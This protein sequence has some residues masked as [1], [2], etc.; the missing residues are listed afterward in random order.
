MAL[1]A[2]GAIGG[3]V[4]GVQHAAHAGSRNHH[5]RGVSQWRSGDVGRD[6]PD[7]SHS[8]GPA[9]V[10]ISV[11]SSSK[12]S[13]DD[14]ADR[15][16]GTTLPPPETRSR[17]SAAS[18]QVRPRAR[19][20]SGR[21]VPNHPYWGSGFI[22]SPDGI[23]LTNAHVVK[24]AKE[25]TVKLTDRREY[26]A[27]VLGADPKPTWR[28]CASTPKTC[29]VVQLGKWRTCVWANGLAIGSPFG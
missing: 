17:F 27:K 8:Y 11:V 7:K 24:G 3:A 5:R 10:N 14:V 6:P 2:A 12:A 28:C 13:A 29:A 18:S 20:G 22:V 15:T 1:L 16:T 4:W 25:V 9:V 23:I 26:R 21:T 19:S